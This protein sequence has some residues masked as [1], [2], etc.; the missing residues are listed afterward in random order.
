MRSSLR[1]MVGLTRPYALPL[2]ALFWAQIPDLRSMTSLVISLFERLVH[3]GQR[4]LYTARDSR[5]NT[6]RAFYSTVIHPSTNHTRLS[7]SRKKENFCCIADAQRKKAGQPSLAVVDQ[8]EEA[9]ENEDVNASMVRSLLIVA[10]LIKQTKFRE[11]VIAG[12]VLVKKYDTK[13]VLG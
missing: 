5:L 11:A 10:D 8:T 12:I 9:E 13:N 6:L 2:T 4:H 3:F 1:N 7:Q